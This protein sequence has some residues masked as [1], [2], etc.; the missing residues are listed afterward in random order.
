MGQQWLAAGSGALSAVVCAWDLLKEVASILLTSTI[1][2]PQVKQKGGNIA[3][4]N[5]RKL[6]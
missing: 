3:P 5:N 1:V 2:W 4:P 6:D